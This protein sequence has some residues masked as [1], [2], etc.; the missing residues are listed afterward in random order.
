M[1]V[2]KNLIGCTKNILNINQDQ[3]F[4]ESRTFNDNEKDKLRIWI[5][6]LSNWINNNYIQNSQQDTF[7]IPQFFLVVMKLI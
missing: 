7:I 4:M 6:N 3:N 5:K 2:L 1:T